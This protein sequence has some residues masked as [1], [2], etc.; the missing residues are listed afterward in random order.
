ME[1]AETTWNS[2]PEPHCSG[3]HGTEGK[4]M[5]SER[6]DAF[7]KHVSRRGVTKGLLAGGVAGA[8]GLLG[9]QQSQAGSCPE[10]CAR[11][12]CGGGGQ[13]KGEC[14]QACLCLICDQCHGRP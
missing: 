2:G 10:A 7:T 11:G 4:V 6:F 14:M 9:R 3:T 8:L 13:G 12:F 1:P 5:A